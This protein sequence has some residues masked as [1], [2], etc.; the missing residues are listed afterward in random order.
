MSRAL[1]RLIRTRSVWCDAYIAALTLTAA[2]MF[3]GTFTH[4]PPEAWDLNAVLFLA[5]TMAVAERLAVPLPRGGAVSIATIPHMVGALL[6][7]PWVAMLAAGLGMLAD[8]VVGRTG[9][10][11]TAFNVSSVVLTV[12]AT[13]L[14]ADWLGLERDTLGRPEQ[15]QQV[16]AFLVVAALY[17]A[18]T[19]LF[20]STIVSISTGT[21][22]QRSLFENAS[23]ALPAEV[24]VCGIGALIAVL[25]VLSPPWV[26]LILFPAVVSQVTLMYI[27]SSKRQSE[28]LRHQAH[29]D[30]LTGLPNRS[31]FTMSLEEILA[32][33]NPRPFALLLL[34]L[35]RFKEVNDTFGHQSGDLL[36][37]EIGPR[38]RG[39]LRESD[40]LARLGGDEFAL[41]LPTADA[42]GGVSMA[43]RLLRALEEPFGIDGHAFQ[44]GGSIG[45]ATYP[46][47]GNSPSDLM[48][49]ADVAMYAAK[50]GNF[51]V[52]VYAPELDANSPEQVNLYGELRRAIESGELRLH[53]Q[54]K[55]NVCTG[56]LSGVEALVRW[57]HPD[58]GLVNPDQFIPVAERTGLI[59][60]LGRWVMEAAVRQCRAWE[61]E[62]LAIE[63]AVNLAAYNLDEQG[64]SRS[65]SELLA[66]YAVP[67]QRLRV[68]ITETTLMRDPDNARR[69]L[70]EL[71]ADGVHVSID[72][73]G[74]GY[75]SL[76][77]LKRLPADEL[78]ID[79]SFVQH[80]AIDAGDTAIVRSVIAL[81]HEL[82]LLVTAEGVEDAASLEWLRAFGCDCAQG[83]YFARP[84]DADTLRD[85]FL[86]RIPGGAP[87]AR[88]GT[89][90]AAHSRSDRALVA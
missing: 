61:D 46:A 86:D 35:D 19:N 29:H 16:P 84:M 77:Y 78:K 81:G 76:A 57:Q 22:I 82:G 20:V 69:V 67:A 53:F 3:I 79:R 27:S 56:L 48:R 58:R 74:T 42:E 7:P 68:E 60:P 13:A 31:S 52:T 15:W 44:V 62:G 23:F 45:I 38:L 43:E 11:K 87:L 5:A 47:D 40:V 90:P 63:V 59:R 18:A 72:D 6:L 85:S 26:L 75:S 34:D 24:G 33:P 55:V 4:T 41:L 9:V 66:R 8:Q 28:Q 10:R 50:R 73:F 32:N 39:V 89:M 12:G 37:R 30:L 70:D 2:A 51:G 17:Y 1:L 80:M 83:Y 25:W 64:L 14:A 36:L 71:R 65:I 49:R 88:V 21:P 54:P